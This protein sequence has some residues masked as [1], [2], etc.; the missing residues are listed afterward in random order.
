MTS[1]QGWILCKPVHQ[2]SLVVRTNLYLKLY[3][4]IID[5]EKSYSNTIRHNETAKI[6]N[7]LITIYFS[8]MCF[9]YQQRIAKIASSSRR[10]NNWHPRKH[11]LY[12]YSSVFKL[13][14]L[15]QITN[16][17]DVTA[18]RNDYTLLKTM[19]IITHPRS[20][21]RSRWPYTISQCKCNDFP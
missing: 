17:V 2:M 1:G 14:I 21:S 9:F 15:L 5:A 18:W 10:I 6:T 3:W 4:S 8:I 19:D 7:S 13:Q 12:N 11:M 20:C 16:T